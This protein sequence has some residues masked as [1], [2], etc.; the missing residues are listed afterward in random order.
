MGL[1]GSAREGCGMHTRVHGSFSLRGRVPHHSAGP[2]RLGPPPP[3]SFASLADC[4]TL[5]LPP[6]YA[7][8]P[9][10]LPLPTQALTPQARVCGAVLRGAGQELQVPIPH[11][12]WAGLGSQEAGRGRISALRRLSFLQICETEEALGSR[13]PARMGA[14]VCGLAMGRMRGW[15]VGWR[16]ATS[17][18]RW[19]L[20]CPGL[21]PSA[22]T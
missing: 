1:A 12:C 5:P 3:Q 16:R 2:S 13:I 10:L 8:G 20:P 6:P 15:A 7:S 14:T 21:A 17:G 19:P 11:L 9:G 18:Q 4:S 22:N